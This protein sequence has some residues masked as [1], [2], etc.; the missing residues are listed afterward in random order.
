MLVQ[1]RPK[2]HKAYRALPVLGPIIDEFTDW[3]HR[4]GYS[5]PAFSSLLGHVRDLADY[6]RRRGLR[7]WDELTH[8]HFQ[9]AWERLRKRS[10]TWGGTIRQV[11]HFLEQVHGLP[12]GNGQLSSRSEL[13]LEQY[14]QYLRQERCFAEHTIACHHSCVRFFLEFL[15]YERSVCVL[16]KLNIQQVEAFMRAR[17]KKCCRR[18]LR[19]VIG[20]LRCFLRYLYTLGKLVYRLDDSLELPRTYRL[21]Q[22]PKALPWRQI[23]ALL[24]SIDRHGRRGLSACARTNS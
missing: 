14:T 3:V 16:R 1:L 21:E 18:T 22:L 10:N 2:A 13:L 19:D 20:Y 8:E 12:K 5:M 4:S 6:F 23:Q 15:G 9:M 24:S 17:S 7:R 11:Q